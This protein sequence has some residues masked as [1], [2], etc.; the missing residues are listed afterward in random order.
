MTD[1]ERV[2]A[3]W[4]QQQDNPERIKLTPTREKLLTKQLQRNSPDELILLIRYAYEAN[5]REARFWRGEELS[6]NGRK[7]LGLDNILRSTKIPHRLDSARR[8]RQRLDD[9]QV[10]EGV[11]LSFI[12]NLRQQSRKKAL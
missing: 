8:W 7:Y 10:K 3:E 2:F 5:T 12:G 9:H 1:V 6:S 4:Q 11:I